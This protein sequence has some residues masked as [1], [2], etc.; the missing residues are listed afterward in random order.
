MTP[1]PSRTA[2]SR[3]VAADVDETLSGEEAFFDQ[4]RN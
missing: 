1:L 4:D 2:P 3:D